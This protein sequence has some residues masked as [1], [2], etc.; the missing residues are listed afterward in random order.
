M[1]NLGGQSQLLRVYM[2]S[3]PGAAS[4]DSFDL[5]AQTQCGR[6]WHWLTRRA[7]PRIYSW[8]HRLIQLFASTS[9][10]ILVIILTFVAL[11]L[12]DMSILATNNGASDAVVQDVIFVC[13]IFFTLEIIGS[14]TVQDDYF[15]SFFF[16][17]D[18]IGTFR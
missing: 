13:F 14:V 18:A 9:F 11:F 6:F 1:S 12:V 8:K 4:I 2:D 17:C 7:P 10:S 15:L 5:R 16:L 3:P